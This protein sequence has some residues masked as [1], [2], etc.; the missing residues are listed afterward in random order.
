M[1]RSRRRKK[2]HSAVS[3]GLK[4]ALRFTRIGVLLVLDG[5]VLHL[6]KEFQEPVTRQEL[7]AFLSKA[8]SDGGYT[9][10]G[11]LASYSDNSGF[12]FVN[13]DMPDQK[14]IEAELLAAFVPKG[15][16]PL[17]VVTD[18]VKGLCVEVPLEDKGPGWVN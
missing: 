2:K 7:S 8:F 16:A 6:R 13:P 3:T 11:F 5:S 17:R 12:M 15:M 1:K 9:I 10:L 18:P 14:A 4:S